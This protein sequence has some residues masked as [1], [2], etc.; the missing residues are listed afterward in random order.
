MG[1]GQ[2]YLLAA[3]AAILA[4]PILVLGL[5]AP[6][7]AGLIAAAAIFF[8]LALYAAVQPERP[9]A[10]GL[11]AMPRGE[12][13]AARAALA[14]ARPALGRLDAVVDQ[15]PKSQARERLQRLA[16]A[17][18]QVLE[19]V[20]EEPR[21]L[22]PAQRLLTYYLPR[23]AEFAEAHLEL[24]QKGLD[25]TARA[26][27]VE[28]VL[29]KLEQAFARFTEELVDFDMASLDAELRL[30]RAALKDDLGPPTT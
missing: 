4:M 23:A 12:H 1:L 27:A 24:R 3:A 26:V 30:V 8:A 2:R 28:E 9:K 16:A 14:D 18:R 10:A 20:A 25:D 13:R 7:W 11:N 29:Q 15:L 17:A 21:K 6:V 5:N 19:E 22:A